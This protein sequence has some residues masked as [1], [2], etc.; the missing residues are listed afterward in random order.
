MI[1]GILAV[2]SAGIA[3]RFL[4][5]YELEANEQTLEN[6]LKFCAKICG[7]RVFPYFA[8]SIESNLGNYLNFEK[9]S[10]LS[11]EEGHLF[12]FNNYEDEKGN[13]MKELPLEIGLTGRCIAQGKIVIS[14]YGKCDTFFNELVDNIIRMPNVRNVVIIPLFAIYG[15]NM[16]ERTMEKTKS[17]LVGVLQLFNCK[18]NIEELQK[19]KSN[20]I[21][22]TN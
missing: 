6:L 15:N 22:G 13:Y 8:K 7:E 19:V 9:A 21:I 5:S 3:H 20:Y 2:Y 16:T 1:A 4:E 17:K 18:G 12:T 11:L 10:V 14:A